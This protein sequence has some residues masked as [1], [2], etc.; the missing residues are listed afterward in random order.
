MGAFVLNFILVN[1]SPLQ[2]L[3]NKYRAKPSLSLSLSLFP[4]DIAKIETLF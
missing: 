2:A 1:L 4:F 3:F